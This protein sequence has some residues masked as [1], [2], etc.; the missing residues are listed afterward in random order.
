LRE[1]ADFP[2]WRAADFPEPSGADSEEACIVIDADLSI[3]GADAD[4]FAS[5][6]AQVREE[7]ACVDEATYAEARTRVLLSFL[8]REAIYA[9]CVGR[10]LWEARARRNLEGSLGRLRSLP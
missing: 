7:Y 5:Y 6:E 10:R 2:E 3:L 9:T 4:A 1:T 8:N